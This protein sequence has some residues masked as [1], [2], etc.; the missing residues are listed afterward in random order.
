MAKD[1]GV[2]PYSVMTCAC[3]RPAALV[4]S[5]WP[6]DMCAQACKPTGACAG[7]PDPEATERD[8]TMCSAV[9]GSFSMIATTAATSMPVR[10]SPM[11]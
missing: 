6:T 5:S 11:Y 7:P 10:L 8:C 3:V 2:R 1:F 4:Y 9:S